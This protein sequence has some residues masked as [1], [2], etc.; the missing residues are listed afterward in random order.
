MLL[1]NR[2]HNKGTAFTADERDVFH[3]NGLLPPVVEDLDTE[4]F[5]GELADDGDD[6]RGRKRTAY[7]YHFY[8]RAISVC[9]TSDRG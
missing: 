5:P 6:L 9:G 3:L 1:A 7:S 4:V 2:Y 8:H